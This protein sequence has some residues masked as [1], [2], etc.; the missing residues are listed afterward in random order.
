MLRFPN[1]TRAAF[2]LV[3]MAVLAPEAR[4]ATN[5]SD[6]AGAGARWLVSNQQADGA[7]FSPA[8]QPDATATTVVAIVAGGGDKKAVGRALSYMSKNAEISARASA[9]NSGRIVAGI[10]AGGGDPKNFGGVDHVRILTSFFDPATGAYDSTD[11]RN[12]LVAANGVIASGNALPAAAVRY[13][14]T[15]Q[16]KGG[17]TASGFAETDCTSGPDV[18]TTAWA[19]SVLRAAGVKVTDAAIVRAKNFLATAQNRDGGFGSQPGDATRADATGLATSAIYAMRQDP[20]GR[21]W[22]RP[23]GT[24][25]HALRSLQASSGGFRADGSSSDPDESSTETAV[26]G[27]GGDPYPIVPVVTR[28]APANGAGSAPAAGSGGA[29][30]AQGATTGS[31]A[32][33]FL[34]PNPDH[35][36]SAQTPLQTAR[37]CDICRRSSASFSTPKPAGGDPVVRL[38]LFALGGLMLATVMIFGGY[39]L[40]RGRVSEADVEGSSSGAVES[41]LV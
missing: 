9:A 16:C 22:K 12:D 1:V 6:A 20:G 27:L 13:V 40:L 18:E 3:A 30:G 24:P 23:D 11:L 31:G 15:Q 29:K 39:T 36:S 35:L 5:A 19:I 21:D 8:Q 4:A 32:G 14:K 2:V 7:F 10:V 26:P 34:D 38:R 41:E 25:V 17:K 33:S 28:P 37:P